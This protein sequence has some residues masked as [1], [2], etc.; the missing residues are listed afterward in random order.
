MI[1]I[2]LLTILLSA[3]LLSH[4]AA[5]SAASVEDLILGTWHISDKDPAK[6]TQPVVSTYNP[7][8]TLTATMYMNTDC[9]ASA[10][11]THGTWKIEGQKLIITVTDS[12]HKDIHPIGFEIIDT[13]VSIDEQE[14]VL[15]SEH[16]Q[17]L[18]YRTRVSA[19]E[20]E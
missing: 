1:N 17:T 5:V 4:F 16:D 11:T 18:M 3:I 15:R 12:S 9:Y 13:I 20:G 7:D 2:R 8:N 14:K 10:L 6:T 19:C